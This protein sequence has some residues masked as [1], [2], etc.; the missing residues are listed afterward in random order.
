MSH[1]DTQSLQGRTFRFLASNAQEAAQLVRNHLGPEARVLSVNT[2][3]PKGLSRFLASP[4]LEVIATLPSAQSHQ[5]N[6]S[7][8]PTYPKESVVPKTEAFILKEQLNSADE[9]TLAPATSLAAVLRRCGFSD[10][11]LGSLQQKPDWRALEQKPMEEGLVEVWRWFKN[12]YQLLPKRPVSSRLAF[13]GIAGSGKTSALC[14]WLKAHPPAEVEQTGVLS[15]QGKASTLDPSLGVFCEALGLRLG[16]DKACLAHWHHPH[17]I[18]V[19]TFS[20]GIHEVE[21]WLLLRNTL[22]EMA[23]ETRIMVVHSAYQENLIKAQLMIAER[24]GAT[25]LVLSHVEEL[26]QIG[27]LWPFVLK[28]GLTPLF[29]S[30]G[31]RLQAQLCTDIVR[32]LGNKT[33]PF[34]RSVAL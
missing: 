26:P 6:T 8:Q 9:P 27:H 29:L 2:L 16:Y 21:D 18:Y 13:M 34:L 33:F 22:D 23:I 4:K 14:R 17:S 12:E 11:F 19:D 20:P 30:T 31:G 7:D 25:H 28:S 10:L 24:M 3:Q 15:L 5:N 32:Y 1:T